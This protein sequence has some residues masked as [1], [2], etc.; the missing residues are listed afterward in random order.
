MSTS[1]RVLVLAGLI[2]ATAS[3][4]GA[5]AAEGDVAGSSDH[6]LVGRYAGAVIFD[7]KETEYDE[8][9]MVSGNGSNDLIALEGRITEI[10]YRVPR[11]RSTL[12]V[13]RNYE[14]QLDNAGFEPIFSCNKLDCGGDA[15]AA[16]HFSGRVMGE[17]RLQFVGDFQHEQRY[18][19]ARLAS[20]ESDT[21]VSIYDFRDAA[22]EGHLVHV[23]VVETTQMAQDQIL[24]DAQ[25]MA[26][27]IAET[28]RVSLYGI[29]FDTDE[30]TVRPESQA[31]LEEIATLLASRPRLQL[32][33]V[34]HTDNRGSLDYNMDLSSRRAAAVV[35]SLVEQHGVDRSRLDAWGIGYLAPVATNQTEDGR[36][37]NRRVEL[38]ER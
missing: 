7:Y 18:Q 23:K 8:T 16:I 36:A 9:S 26:K 19:I 28:G 20:P 4:T 10:Y 2:V 35:Q 37:K 34:G 17:R 3:A 13:M 29:Y 24:I 27:S 22:Y 21:Y 5:M 12:E 38:V 33:V 6:P 30:A 1:L 31:T 14:Q 15:T 25:E 32:V 11:E